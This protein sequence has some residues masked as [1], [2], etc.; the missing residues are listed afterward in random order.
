MTANRRAWT[1]D[2]WCTPVHVV[3]MARR[4]LGGTIKLDPFSNPWACIVSTF[5]TTTMGFDDWSDEL[6]LPPS[7]ALVNGPWSKSGEV[8]R[9]VVAQ[10]M[11]GWSVVQIV[12]TSLNS[13]HWRLIEEAPAVC[14]PSKRI[15][16]LRE[17]V[18]VKGNRQDS[19]I[20][21]WSDPLRFRQAFRELGP[22]RLQ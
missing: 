18:A 3:D 12:P 20:V 15:A 2:D 16:Y 11:R 5:S 19:V 17:G 9:H 13:T 7:T 1:K 14:T 6:A 8:V 4:A 21:G 22:V 10:W